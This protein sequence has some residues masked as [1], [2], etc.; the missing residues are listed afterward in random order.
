MAKGD[1]QRRMEEAQ[2]R[3]GAWAL[4]RNGADEVSSACTNVAVVLV[5]VNLITRSPAFAIAAL[6]LLAYSWFRI[7]SKDVS[8]RRAEVAEVSRRLGPVLS[9]LANPMA[10]AREARVYKHL[11]CPSCGQRVR[12]PRGKGKVR[13]TCPKC[14]ARFD[15]RA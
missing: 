6:A 13:V 11:T 7:S 4:G 9:W 8:R 14:H 10:A 12:I 5:V 15:G 1:F 2:R 3:L